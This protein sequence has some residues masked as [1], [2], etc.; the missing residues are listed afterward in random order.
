MVKKSYFPESK[1]ETARLENKTDVQAV[2][3]QSQWAGLKPGMRVLDVGCG[4]GI[5]T[6]A[7]SVAVQPGGVVVGIDQSQERI[8]YACRKYA[9][10]NI[11]FVCRDFFSDLSDLGQFDFIWVR[12]VLEFYLAEGTQLVAHLIKSLRKNGILCLADLDHNCL[13]HYGLSSRLEKTLVRVAECQM[14][15]NNFDPFAGRKLYQFLYDARMSDIKTDLR[16]H[17][18][19]YGNLSEADRIHWWQKIEL[20]GKRSG[21]TFDEYEG[22]YDQF[23][24]EF[25]AFFSDPRRFTYTPLI[26]CRGVK[27]D[28]EIDPT[29]QFQTDHDKRL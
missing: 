12:F 9:D 19:I 14:R 28:F 26:L 6:S 15:T 27:P 20:A 5:T 3:S 13:N 25:K 24:E 23:V 1:N 8:D 7:L 10:G 4:P 29:G 16:A 18:L 22:G 11:N 21:H 2:I 17:H